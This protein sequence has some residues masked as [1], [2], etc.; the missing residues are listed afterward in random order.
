MIE[1]AVMWILVGLSTGKFDEDLD[2]SVHAS[3]DICVEAAI[4][5]KWSEWACYPTVMPTGEG[6]VIVNKNDAYPR[7]CVEKGGFLQG[8]RYVR[9]ADQ[10][11]RSIETPY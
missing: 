6:Y 4:D 3:K 1:T 5:A 7:T 10:P 8:D 2:L 11:P 9:C